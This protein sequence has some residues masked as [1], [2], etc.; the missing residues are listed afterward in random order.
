MPWIWMGRPLLYQGIAARGIVDERRTSFLMVPH[1][2][3]K[4][5]GDSIELKKI[6]AGYP[7][8]K[9]YWIM[10]LLTT[11]TSLDRPFQG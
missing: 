5:D 7:E 11:Y 3:I 1:S 8:R 4:N 10:I 2:I 9:T 6:Q